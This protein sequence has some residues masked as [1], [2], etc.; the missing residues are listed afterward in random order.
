MIMLQ[1]LGAVQLARLMA[2]D[3]EARPDLSWLLFGPTD[4]RVVVP[5][6]ATPPF[7]MAAE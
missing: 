2:A 3:G 7:L 6:P 1:T 5:E 4:P